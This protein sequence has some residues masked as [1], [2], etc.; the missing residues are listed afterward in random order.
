MGATVPPLGRFQWPYGVYPQRRMQISRVKNSAAPVEG[1]STLESACLLKGL[2]VILDKNHYTK[3]A[4]ES[5]PVA[6]FV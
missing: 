5:H 3:K 6:F 4:T 1:A 2:G